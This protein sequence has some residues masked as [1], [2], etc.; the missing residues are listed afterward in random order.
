VL[1][2]FCSPS[3]FVLLALDRQIQRLAAGFRNPAGAEWAS[4]IQERD[5]Q[6][7]EFDE[8]RAIH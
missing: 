6:N 3:A 1:L 2:A 4:N 7:F 8:T 5:Y